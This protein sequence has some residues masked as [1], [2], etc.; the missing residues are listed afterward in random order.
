VSAIA[1]EQDNAVIIIDGVR[2]PVSEAKAAA[3]M[4][5]EIERLQMQNT[6]VA[7]FFDEMADT[8]DAHGGYERAAADCRAMAAR[9]RGDGDTT[10]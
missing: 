6:K 8:F 3:E 5:A 2:V 10:Q 1:I 4:R 9:L 7:A